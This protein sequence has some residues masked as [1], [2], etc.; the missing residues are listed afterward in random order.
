MNALITAYKAAD[1]AY[2]FGFAAYNSGAIS[3]ADLK[4]LKSK[5]A[6]AFSEYSKAKKASMAIG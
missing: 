5:K 1:K 6:K 2:Q 3:L 4:I